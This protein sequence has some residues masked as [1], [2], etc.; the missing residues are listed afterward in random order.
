MGAVPAAEL[1][2]AWKQYRQAPTT[3]DDA[4][5]W[6][7][8]AGVGAALA[9]AL[10]A[11]LRKLWTAAF[12]IGEHAAFVLLGLD[13]E[14]PPEILA[15]LLQD[16]GEKWIQEIVRVRLLRI[17]A[18]L[19]RG[20]TADEIAAEIKALLE[21]AEQAHVI[22]VTEVTRASGYGAAGAYTASGRPLVEWVTAHDA[23]VCPE[24]DANEAAGPRY[25]GTPFP[26]GAVMPPEHPRCRCA[27]VPVKEASA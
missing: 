26:S 27:L 20:G 6:L 8:A 25:L 9:A 15:A 11:I 4:L 7:V 13:S 10:A 5:A 16:Y 21:N 3:D 22:A 14:L 17:A 12:G 19:A 18:I 1:A 23:R 2:A 24:C